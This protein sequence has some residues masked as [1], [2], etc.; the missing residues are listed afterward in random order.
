MKLKFTSKAMIACGIGACLFVT[1]AFADMML[2]SGYD[3]L[4]KSAKHTAAQLAANLDSYTVEGSLSIKIDDQNL[5]YQY[6]NE[7]Y[8]MKNEKYEITAVNDSFQEQREYFKYRDHNQLVTK[9]SNDDNLY[10]HQ[11]PDDYFEN[12][13]YDIIGFPD[14][15]QQDGAAEIEKIVDAV[16]GNLQNLILI[17]NA[18]HGGYIYKGT[19]NASQVPAL[20]NAVSS[21]AIKNSYNGERRYNNATY[22]PEL[23]SDITIESVSGQVQ[24]NADGLITKINGELLLSGKDVNGV[25]HTIEAKL[26][27]EI[28]DIN[29]TVVETP[30]LSNAII[31]TAASSYRN[32]M[33]NDNV[34]GTYT[35]NIV[36]EQEGKIIKIGERTLQIDSISKDSIVGS[37]SEILYEGYEDEY[38][39][40][41]YTF[42]GIEVL[43]GIVVIHY[44]DDE[45]NESTAVSHKQTLDSIRFEPD[46]VV[47]VRDHGSYSYS[48]T[49]LENFNST[50]LK[51]FE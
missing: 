18:D 7:K 33:I 37:L 30:D 3:K 4:K 2:G 23:S 25:S 20:V 44:T 16:V 9:N 42:S 21:Y 26:D 19:L 36:I 6:S 46:V 47:D 43:D 27:V 41:Q 48:S 14:P 8:D 5:S 31:E 12:Y 49:S 28:K 24:E 38:N 13:P 15:F 32:Q 17:D 34:T 11:Y 35:N 40:K 10:V 39:A 1:T 51:V 29:A 22:L 45:G 50:F